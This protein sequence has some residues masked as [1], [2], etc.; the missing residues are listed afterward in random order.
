MALYQKING[1]WTICQ[2]PYVLRNGVWTAVNEAYVK[3]GGVWVRA[4]EYDVTPPSPPV[5]AL[6][7]NDDFETS[8]KGV[9]TLKSRWIRVSVRL[10]GA[11]NDPDARLTRVLTTF[12]G[13]PPTT[14][15][16]GTYTSDTDWS[17][18]NEPWSE[19]RY[20]D[21]G[22]HKDTSVEIMKQ[23]PRNATAG[24]ILKGD[25]TYY[26]TGW[27]LDDA[28]NWSAATPASIHVPKNSI[29]VPN[30]VTKEARIQ[31]NTTGS[32][33]TAGWQSGNLIQQKTP[34]SQGLWLYGNQI[35]DTIGKQGPPTVKLAQIYIKRTDDT[36]NGER[37]RLPVLD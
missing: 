18:P 5:I 14:Q 17:Y 28:G 20:N 7:I 1:V 4:Y 26:F 19:W 22:G 10:P 3:S 16:G 29:E 27:T 35:T 23:W 6:S 32:W 21:Y 24:T 37:Q 33:R 11:V 2:R 8:S 15:F 25:E 9:K 31:P 36:G 12:N 30:V 13:K 34:R